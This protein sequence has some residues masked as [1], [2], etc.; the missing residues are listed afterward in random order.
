MCPIFKFRPNIDHVKLQ[1]IPY[2][3]GLSEFKNIVGVI[4]CV[5]INL[6]NMVCL[7]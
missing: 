7:L 6:V 1:K 2:V 5:S 3:S 4:G